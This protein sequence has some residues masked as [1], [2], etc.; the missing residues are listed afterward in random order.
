MLLVFEDREVP[1]LGVLRCRHRKVKRN[2]PGSDRQSCH[3]LLSESTVPGVDFLK[4]D[5]GY[6]Y[7]SWT[8]RKGSQMF[9]GRHAE[10][11]VCWSIEQ[12]PRQ[13]LREFTA[14]GNASTKEAIS[15]STDRCLCI[16]LEIV[17]SN[18]AV[19]FIRQSFLQFICKMRRFLYGV[20]HFFLL[21]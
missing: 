14:N 12:I 7:D 17:A 20:S 10:S 6:I 4:V 5:K 16:L 18:E 2:P 15:W 19:H 1:T 21:R 3:I 11:P 8:L 9:W 13:R